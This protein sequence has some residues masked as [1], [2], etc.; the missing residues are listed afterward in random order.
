[1]NWKNLIPSFFKSGDIQGYVS[2]SFSL[3]NWPTGGTSRLVSRRPPVREALA[4]ELVFRCLAAKALAV[5]D[6]QP[7]IQRYA[8][9]E[10]QP[11]PRH[12][13]LAA[14]RNPNPAQTWADFLASLIVD[15]D[16]WGRWYIEKIR[17]RTGALVGLRPLDVRGVVGIGQNGRMTGFDPLG[18]EWN[19]PLSQV[20]SW[21]VSEYGTVRNLRREDV[22]ASMFFDERSAMS[23][24]SPVYVALAAV[25]LDQSLTR[26]VDS[27]TRNGGPSGLLKVK[28]R[29]LNKEQAED[30]QERWQNRYRQGGTNEGGVAV[31]DEDADYQQI[32]GHLESLASD[33]LKQHEQA[34]IC[35]AL[36]VPGQIIEA[37][38]AIRWG[39]QRGGQESAQQKFWENTLSPTL[40]RYRQ[41]LDKFFLS[42]YEGERAGIAYRVFY[43]LSSVKALQEDVD[44]VAAR[45]RADFT[46]GIISLNEARAARGLKPVE[47]GDE[48]A[49]LVRQEQA[50][51][52]LE[53]QK[54][55]QGKGDGENDQQKQN[56]GKSAGKP[57]TKAYEWEGL[58][59]ARKPTPVEEKALKRV[60]DAQ[61]AGARTAL[62]AL[63]SVRADLLAQALDQAKRDAAAIAPQPTGEHQAGI[64]A[65][66]R[67]AYAHGRVSAAAESR[68]S[69]PDSERKALGDTVRRIARL[70]L[71]ALANQIAARVVS[72]LTRLLLRD[73]AQADALKQVESLLKDESLSYV[74]EIAQGAA[75]QAVAEGRADE[76]QAGKQPGDRYIYSAILDVNTC[77]VCRAADLKEADDPAKLP[78]APNPD[79]A[80]RWRCRCMIVIARD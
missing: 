36:G 6:T 35:A 3:I 43:D 47:G 66:I 32:G 71:A 5:Q 26:Y 56:Q 10:W 80:G 24:L 25:G 58:Q 50:R 52:A 69:V 79:C 72:N 41:L 4:H 8:T 49:A 76:F 7:V 68:N 40:S 77:D 55:G 13:A 59:L 14:L 38:Y 21:Q 42:E 30:L 60:A 27:Y 65:V 12:P 37:F 62:E 53:Q 23:G 34:A 33:S 57:E 29:K 61:E 18:F 51:V 74:E 75:Y 48:I 2:Q 20:E 73:V 22:I 31:L 1:M 67:A 28:N 78:D 19:L 39:N 11:D 63:K 54:T 16:I 17:S 64:E 45:S 46:A 44:K 9:G 15:E 70:A